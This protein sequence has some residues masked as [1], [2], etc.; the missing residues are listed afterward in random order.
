MNFIAFLFCI[1]IVV[2]SMAIRFVEFNVSFINGEYNLLNQYIN[3]FWFVG[4]TMTTVG[5]G[6]IKPNTIFGRIL[7]YLI[8]LC[9]LLIISL[10][11]GTVFSFIQLSLQEQNVLFIIRNLRLSK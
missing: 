7:A 5:Y 2:F 1:L 4:V 8:F 6:D 11:F 10:T 3:G 9:G